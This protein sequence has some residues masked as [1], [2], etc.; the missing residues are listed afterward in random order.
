MTTEIIIGIDLGTTNSVVSVIE[1]GRPRV[2]GESGQSILPSVVGVDQNGGL[3]VGRPAQN[4]L[5]LAPERT[6]KSIKRRMGE[7]DTVRLGDME[8]TPQEISAVILRK[9]KQMAEDDL[10]R[11]IGKAVITVPAFFNEI[12]REATR[13]AGEMAGLNVVRII[14]EPTAAALAYFPNQHATERVLVYDLG[15]GTFD[16]SVVQIEGGVVEVLA[17]HGD[18]RLGGDDFDQLLFEHVREI[19]LKQHKIDLNESPFS[20]SRL[21]Q[22]VESA[23][24]QLSFEAIVRIDEEFIAESKGVPLNLSLEIKRFDYEKMI[25]P[26]LMRT[27]TCLGKALD[28]AKLT[29]TQ[30]SR[31]LLVGGSTRTPLVRHLLND[32]LGLPLHT[33]VDPDLCVAMGAAM[34]GAIISGADVQAVLV[35]ITPH[36][37]GIQCTGSLAGMRFEHNFSPIITKNS[38]LPISGSE[39]FV[40]ASDGQKS[41]LISVF[42]GENDDVRYNDEV[43]EFELEGLAEVSRGN[44]ILVRFSLDLDGILQ[45]TATEQATGNSRDL[46]I[47]NSVARFRCSNQEAAQSRLDDAFA[48]SGELRSRDENANLNS[49]SM[50]DVPSPSEWTQDKGDAISPELRTLMEEAHEMI[51]RSEPLVENAAPEDAEELREL[52]TRLKSAVQRRSGAELKETLSDLEDL[53]F[54]LQDA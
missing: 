11:P 47:N 17:S 40:T 43:G 19:F 6:V 7:D 44:E 36:S 22:A 29:A 52:L 30:I 38:P 39:M 4:Q 16:V 37:L 31:V 49:E 28:D 46:V 41:A 48:A 23:K 32:R 2:I 53:V 3:I 50:I 33:E 45:V 20:R 26:W 21:L 1:N 14:N 54:Y 25:Q 42:Q 15:G 9:L 5:I 35:D 13:S 8:F 18:T 10:G 27:L 12:Q 51:V 24:I 34:Q